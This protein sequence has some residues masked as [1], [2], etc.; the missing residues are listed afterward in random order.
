MTQQTLTTADAAGV[1]AGT[2]TIAGR[3]V[4]GSAGVTAVVNPS[5]EQVAG[6]MP[7][8]SAADVAAAVEAARA[9]AG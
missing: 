6:L 5:T 3:Q 1:Y 2:M 7:E 8:A 9:L 4:P